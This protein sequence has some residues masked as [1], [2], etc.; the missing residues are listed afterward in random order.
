MHFILLTVI[1]VAF[2][3]EVDEAGIVASDV[4]HFLAIFLDFPP[5]IVLFLQKVATEF[6]EGGQATLFVGK[7]L[8]LD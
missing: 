4:A 8:S 2:L 1:P 6:D 7:V 5:N 3:I